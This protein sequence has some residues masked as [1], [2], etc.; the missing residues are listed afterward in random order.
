MDM[1]IHIKCM[2]GG[3]YDRIHRCTCAHVTLEHNQRAT[4]NLSQTHQME[5]LTIKMGLPSSVYTVALFQAPSQ[6]F[7]H[8]Q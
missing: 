7:G 5:N 8:L 4:P 3:K 2:V 1:I 6:L